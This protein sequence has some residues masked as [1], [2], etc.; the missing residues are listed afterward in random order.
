MHL[1]FK[2]KLSLNYKMLIIS[3]NNKS[4]VSFLRNYVLLNVVVMYKALP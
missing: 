3:F 1:I 2:T 4:L